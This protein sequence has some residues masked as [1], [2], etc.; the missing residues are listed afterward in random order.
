MATHSH[1]FASSWMSIEHVEYWQYFLFSLAVFAFYHHPSVRPHHTEANET[2]ACRRNIWSWL[3]VSMLLYLNLLFDF[4]VLF[5]SNPRCDWEKRINYSCFSRQFQ[6]HAECEGSWKRAMQSYV[7][8]C[9][10]F[11][12]RTHRSMNF[13]SSFSVCVFSD[14]AKRTKFTPHRFARNQQWNRNVYDTTFAAKT[15][16]R[17]PSKD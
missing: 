16:S 13:R 1:T 5:F 12:I 11:P 2:R 7:V 14:V 3:R 6:W 10:K 8:V 17:N 9:T 15:K 4:D